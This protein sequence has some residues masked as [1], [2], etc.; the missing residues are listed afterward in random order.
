MV[1]ILMLAA[2]A[3]AAAP[4]EPSPEAV[5][6]GVEIAEHGTL[7]ALLPLKQQQDIAE[8]LAEDKS[9]SAAQQTQLKT[10]TESLYAAAQRRLFTA[11]GRAYAERLSLADLRRI[12]AFYRSPA[13]ARFQAAVPVAIVQTMK[14]VGDL[15][16]KKEARAAFCK[17]TGKLCTPK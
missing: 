3:A 9:L 8:L 4:A 14:A 15:D 10:T 11:T 16:L 5:R 12:A 7:A 2:A 17:D 6:L 13:A 1:I